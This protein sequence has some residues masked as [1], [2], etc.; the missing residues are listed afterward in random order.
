MLNWAWRVSGIYV[1][2]IGGFAKK[3]GSFDSGN[4]CRNARANSGRG[5]CAP[6]PGRGVLFKQRRAAA[7]GRLLAAVF[8]FGPSGRSREVLECKSTLN[9]L[10]IKHERVGWC[11]AEDCLPRRFEARA[12]Q[13]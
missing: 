10:G 3:A 11:R 5:A 13:A 2:T 7:S 12:P 9:R 1:T 8:Q 6:G 4:S